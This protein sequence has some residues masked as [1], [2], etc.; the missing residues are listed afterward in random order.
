MVTVNQLDYFQLAFEAVVGDNHQGDIAIDD[1]D[2]IDGT[3]LNIVPTPTGPGGQFD[4]GDGTTIP[5]SKQ[6][7]FVRQCSVNNDEADCGECDFERD[8]CRFVD[9]STGQFKWY[10]RS[11]ATD[12]PATGPGSDHTNLFGDGFYMVVDAN[13]GQFNSFAELQGPMLQQTSS[14]CEVQFWYHMFGADIGTLMLALNSNNERTR[15]FQMSG[16]QSPNWLRARVGIGR[17]SSPFQMSFEAVRSFSV[18][19]DIALDD[20]SL[21]NC[22]LPPRQTQCLD[23]DIQFRCSSGACVY[24]SYLCDLTDD[25]G[26]NS[27]EMQCCKCSLLDRIS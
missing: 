14:S 5:M 2:S 27:D 23:T 3:C 11:N 25:C 9:I 12:T 19:G 10:R 20:V 24:N 26:D 16:N 4:C 6:C 13:Q 22:A 7:D 8:Q 1:L 15:V 21:R 18:V 17:L